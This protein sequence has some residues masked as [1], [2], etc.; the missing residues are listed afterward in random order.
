MALAYSRT[1]LVAISSFQTRTTINSNLW[2]SLC[3]LGIS[4]TKP[5]RGGCRAGLR[6]L[7][8]PFSLERPGLE[9]TVPNVA[10]SIAGFHMTSLKPLILL[11]FYFHDVLEQLKANIQTNFH[12]EWLLG[13]AID[14]ARISKLLRDVTFT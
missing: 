9:S 5:T 12:S 4:R 3:Q 14:Y 2:R 1:M 8:T 11:R 13:L 10:D 7:K 6:K